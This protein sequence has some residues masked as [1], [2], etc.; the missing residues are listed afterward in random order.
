M[1]I[2]LIIQK[3]INKI[4]SFKA[5]KIQSELFHYNFDNE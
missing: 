1:F 4:Q 5:K 2:S 3:I